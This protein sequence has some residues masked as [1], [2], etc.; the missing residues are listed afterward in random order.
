MRGRIALLACFL[1]GSVAGHAQWMKSFHDPNSGVGFFYPG[2][3]A[4]GGGRVLSGFGNHD[5]R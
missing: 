1:L 2:H 5:D 3:G 4:T